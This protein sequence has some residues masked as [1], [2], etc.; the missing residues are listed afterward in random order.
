MS[1]LSNLYI[2]LATSLDLWNDFQEKVTGRKWL[3]LLLL[4]SQQ[5]YISSLYFGTSWFCYDVNKEP[6]KMHEYAMMLTQNLLN[7]EK[8]SW[9]RLSAFINFSAT[10]QN[11]HLLNIRRLLI[12]TSTPGC[13]VSRLLKN[14]ISGSRIIINRAKRLRCLWNTVVC[15]YQQVSCAGSKLKLILSFPFE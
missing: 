11:T 9:I 12:K 13:P 15:F 7:F 6:T 5:R 4:L 10:R 8:Y 2:L 14:F 1:L 3:F